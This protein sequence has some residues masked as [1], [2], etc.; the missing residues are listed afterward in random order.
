MAE[1]K[2]IN[3]WFFVSTT[4]SLTGFSVKFSE[5]EED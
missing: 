3:S 1:K 2:G 5:K 4:S